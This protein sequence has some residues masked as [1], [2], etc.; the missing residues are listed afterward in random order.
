[1]YT[2]MG[3]SL[4]KLTR[5]AASCVC[6]FKVI[7]HVVS[8]THNSELIHCDINA[9]PMYRVQVWSRKSLGSRKVPSCGV[10]VASVYVIHLSLLS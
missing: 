5:R 9:E 1:M 3:F 2:K 7:I 8:Y 10:P 6:K 4:C